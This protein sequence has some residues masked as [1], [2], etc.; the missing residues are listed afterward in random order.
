MQIRVAQWIEHRKNAAIV[1]SPVIT[2][3]SRRLFHLLTNSTLAGGEGG[4]Y[5]ADVECLTGF[6]RRL[7]LGH[8]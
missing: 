1:F 3:C 7:F 4:E 5:F 6:R 2:H 8:N